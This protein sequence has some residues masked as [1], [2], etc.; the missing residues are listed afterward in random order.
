M[1]YDI[2]VSPK[3]LEKYNVAVV[4]SFLVS[5]SVF[6]CVCDSSAEM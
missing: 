5:L 4:D 6:V 2:G 3:E 1:I